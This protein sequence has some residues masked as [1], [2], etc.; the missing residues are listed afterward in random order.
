MTKRTHEEMET[1]T[2]QLQKDSGEEIK[3]S[4]LRG[5]EAQHVCGQVTFPES[6]NSWAI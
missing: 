3:T 5:Q 4:Y 1:R 6:F 2:D